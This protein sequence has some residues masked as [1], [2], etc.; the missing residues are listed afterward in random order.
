M[1]D[2]GFNGCSDNEDSASRQS[3]CRPRSPVSRPFSRGLRSAPSR[4][5]P[6]TRRT[7]LE[8][9]LYGAWF[10][11]E[12]AASRC[13]RNLT[14]RVGLRHE[15][16]TGWNEVVGC[17][18][19]TM[20]PMPTGVLMTYSG[21]RRI[22]FT[23]RTTPRSFSRPRIGLAYDPFS[24]TGKTSDPGGLRNLLLAD[25]FHLAFSAELAAALLTARRPIRTGALSVDSCRLLRA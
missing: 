20:S 22:P 16:S 11:Q 12:D 3:G 4:S 2:S 19:P 9:R 14:I 5:I 13:G 17:A 8:K 23:R 24:A 7:G 18:P 15:F 6:A 1:W 21:D 25:R 10:V